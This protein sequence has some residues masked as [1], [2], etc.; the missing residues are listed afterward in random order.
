MIHSDSNTV[1]SLN[2]FCRTLRLCVKKTDVGDITIPVGTVVDI[3]IILLHT[4]PDYWPEPQRFDPERLWFGI[5]NYYK[6][7]HIKKGRRKEPVT[8]KPVDSPVCTSSRSQHVCVELLH[9]CFTLGQVRKLHFSTGESFCC[10]C[11]NCWE[12][13]TLPPPFSYVLLL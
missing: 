2:I 5:Q 6:Q 9:Q 10:H 8:V 1:S 7:E 3:P 4:N 13:H 11:S 12:L